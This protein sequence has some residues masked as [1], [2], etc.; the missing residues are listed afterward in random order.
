M[1]TEDPET[2]VSR[3]VELVK[4]RIPR[5]FGLDAVRDNPVLCPM[6]RGGELDALVSAYAATAHESQGSE[7]PAAVIPVLTQH[8]AMLKRNLLYTGVTRGK[9][10]LVLVGQ[11]KGVAIAM[12]NGS[13]RRRW[14]RLPSMQDPGHDAATL[15][16]RGCRRPSPT[17]Y[18]IQPIAMR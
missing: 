4:T 12:R 2:A 17:A 11:K 6:N 7:L 9:R 8:Y 15:A 18:R 3:I 5:R 16:D 1:A 14:S 10:L 13:G